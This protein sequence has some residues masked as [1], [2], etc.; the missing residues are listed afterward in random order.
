MAGSRK[1]R[2]DIAPE[3]RGAF[4][5]GILIVQEKTGKGLSELIA[6]AINEEGILK[7]MDAIAKYVPKEL[8][9]TNTEMTPEQ[10]LEKMSDAGQPESTE[11]ADSV[12][13]PVH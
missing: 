5:R 1:G 4:K 8:D 10:W 12:Q 13:R 7:V 9:V 3:I 11:S 2:N 6:D